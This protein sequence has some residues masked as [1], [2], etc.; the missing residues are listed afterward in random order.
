MTRPRMP[1]TGPV[2]GVAMWCPLGTKQVL[3]ELEDGD[4]VRVPQ[5]LL[6]AAAIAY[7]MVNSEGRNMVIRKIEG[8]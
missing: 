5:R 6:N 2:K 3:M 1:T 4:I 8:A 7:F